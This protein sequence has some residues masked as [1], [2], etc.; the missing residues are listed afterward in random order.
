MSETQSF[1]VTLRREDGYRFGADWGLPG[2]A[3]GTLDEPAPVGKG[4]GPNAARLV[5]AAVAHCLSSSLLFCLEKARAPAQ[6]IRTVATAE[7]ARNEKGRWRLV[8]LRVEIE[9]THPP[10][11]AA[12]LERCKGLFEEFCIVTESV[13]KGIPV[14]VVWKAGPNPSPSA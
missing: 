7:V 4:T 6:S 12:Q 5:A 2:V 13:R 8:H 11:L 10:E 3:E 14:D 9:P 1:T